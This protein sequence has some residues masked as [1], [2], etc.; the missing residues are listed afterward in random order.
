LRQDDCKIFKKIIQDFENFKPFDDS[1]FLL[2][3]FSEERYERENLFYKKI[4]ERLFKVN[5]NLLSE[6]DKISHELLTFVIKKKIADFNFKTHYNPILSDAGFHNNLVYRVK[7]ISSIDQA[8]HYI[9]TLGEIPNFVRQNIKLISKGLD[10]GISQPKIIFEGYNTTYEKHITLSYKNNFYYSP[11]LK[12]PTSIP[13]YM[14][15]SLQVLAANIITDS[16]IP[17]F[18][19]IKYFF[20]KEYLPRTR[21]KIGVSQTPNGE[22]YYESRIR[23]YT[24]LE[25]KPKEIHN[26]GIAE[27]EKIKKQMFKVISE[28]KFQGDFKEFL[29]FLRTN[30]KFYASSPKE[31][32]V[33]ARDI[34]KRLDE[35]LP[36]FFKHLPRQPYGVAPV[37]LSIAP[38]YTGG[39]YIPAPKDGTSPGLYWVNTY[40]LPSRPLF[41]IPALTAHEAVP[42]HHLQGALNKELPE[43]IPK[44]RKDLYLSA[45]GEGWGLYSELLAEEMGIYTNLYEK[46]GQLSYSMWRACRLVVDTGIHSFN[47]TRE[48]AINYM[49]DNTALSEH[50]INTEVDRY[51][52]WP[53]QALSYKIGELKIIELRKKAEKK[54]KDKFNIR[55]FH[56]SI[57]KNGTLTLPLLQDQISEY[58]AS[59]LSKN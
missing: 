14:K 37:P 21:S 44:F 54:L 2:E 5:K 8:Y 11:F 28:V 20:E 18:K 4:Y 34:A 12:L 57:L 39:R 1:V 9:K 40:N 36:R 22:K 31:L 23:Y 17:S 3:D 52:S 27:V 15:D 49:L 13:N 35:Q 53:G 24:T 43:S 46:F 56:E 50:E 48:Q 58:I 26:I 45:F 38:K 42:G 59:N 55:D 6:Q 25:L 30:K 41:N 29:N 32:L 47:W 7:K 33:H 16:V 19:K 10:M 51:I